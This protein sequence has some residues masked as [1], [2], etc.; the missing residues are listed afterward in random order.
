MTN[1]YLRDTKKRKALLAVSVKT[2]SAIEGIP[3]MLRKRGRP[4]V[5]ASDADRQRAYRDRK[6]REPTPKPEA[7]ASQ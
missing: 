4:R 2:S 6:R 7:P 5:H 1:K 3:D